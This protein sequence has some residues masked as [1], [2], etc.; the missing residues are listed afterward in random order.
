VLERVAGPLAVVLCCIAAF[1]A[2]GGGNEGP[3]T[4]ITVFAA[5]SLTETFNDAAASF[6]EQHGDI[7][8]QFNFAGSPTLRAQLDQGADADVYAAADEENM[9]AALDAGLV[10]P[11]ARTFARNRLAIIVPA[12][13]PG[14]V[15]LLPDLAK[16]GLRVVVAAPD[17]PAGRYTREALDLIAAD[18]GFVPGF[19]EAVL[20][21]VVS[22]EPNVKAVVAKVQLGEADAGI[23]YVTDVTPEIE[24]DVS[25]IEIPLDY[26]VQA[27]Y[28][29]AVTSDAE[30]PEAAQAF[31]DFL[32]SDGGQDILE[33]HRFQRAP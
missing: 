18:D 31:I 27:S 33:E 14:E 19:R 8:V 2:C 6:E 1:A 16:D 30:H 24:S 13:N 4:T 26:N 22:E 28:Q 11:E 25:V 23:V 9:Q 12:D 15:H 21:N 5:S 32:L 3:R 29:A 7:D 10:K 17:V 20:S